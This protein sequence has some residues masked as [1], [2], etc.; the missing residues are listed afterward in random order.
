MKK[1]LG[2]KKHAYNKAHNLKIVVIKVKRLI[3]NEDSN[4]ASFVFQGECTIST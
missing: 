4:R 2:E 3:T 1:I